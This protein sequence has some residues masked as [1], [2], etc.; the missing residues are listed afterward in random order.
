MSAKSI[1]VKLLARR[2]HS[3]QEIRQKL[4][5]RE[6]DDKEI[7]QVVIDLQQGGW[8]SDE[9]FTE[10]YIRMRMVKGFGP[11]RIAME[12]R[13][14]GVDDVLVDQYLD[15]RAPEWLQSLREQ[16][17]KKY[18]GKSIEDYNDKAKRI[19]FLQ[20]RGFALDVIHEV[21]GDM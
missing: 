10:A 1:A 17:H 5:Q 15:P 2:E 19:R 7:D 4:R 6:F 20:Y 3:A 8:L 21:L 18:A 13:E 11:V 16:Y 12:L 9:R 14:R